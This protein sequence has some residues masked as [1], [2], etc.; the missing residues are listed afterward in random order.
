MQDTDTTKTPRD[1]V[2]I[3]YKVGSSEEVRAVKKRIRE[4]EK[5]RKR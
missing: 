2:K 5:R 1:L 4:Q 3:L